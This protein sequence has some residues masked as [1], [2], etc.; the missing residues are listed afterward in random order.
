MLIIIA[1]TAENLTELTKKEVEKSAP[2]CQY[3][4]SD[5]VVAEFSV[6]VVQNIHHQ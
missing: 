3:K 6:F 4:I 5:G 1:K 2:N